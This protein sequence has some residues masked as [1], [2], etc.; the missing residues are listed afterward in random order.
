MKQEK[1]K[2]RRKRAHYSKE[3]RRRDGTSIGLAMR[4]VKKRRRVQRRMWTLNRSPHGN[5]T[6]REQRGREEWKAEC[7]IVGVEP[8]V[9]VQVHGVGYSKEKTPWKVRRAGVAKTTRIEE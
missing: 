9:Q 7:M 6:A 2:K 5:K 4:E 3:Q 8:T 1:R